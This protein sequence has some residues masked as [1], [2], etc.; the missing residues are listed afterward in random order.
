MFTFRQ[1]SIPNQTTNSYKLTPIRLG[2][3]RKEVSQRSNRSGLSIPK[4]EPLEDRLL[5]SGLLPNTVMQRQLNAFNNVSDAVTEIGGWDRVDVFT[6]RTTDK[7]I[8][9]TDVQ[10]L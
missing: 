8:Q 2:V 4:L 7:I 6:N 10:A 5:L 9:V 3:H 1:L